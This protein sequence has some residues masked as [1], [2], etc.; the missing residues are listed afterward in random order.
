VVF[1]GGGTGG[2]V[3]PGLAL[4]EALRQLKPTIQ[5]RWI[6][7]RGRIE[8]RAVPRAGVEITYLEVSFLK[9]R[10]GAALFKAGATIPR[11]VLEAMAL[12]RSWRAGAVVGLGGFV[13]GPVC[14]AASI[15]RIPVFLLEQNAVPGLTNRWAARLARTVYVSF[16]ESQNYFPLQRTVVAGNPVRSE[17]VHLRRRHRPDGAPLNLLVFGG[18]QG[19]RVL[20]SAAPSVIAA[21]SRNVAAGVSVWHIAGEAARD[22]VDTAYQQAGVHAR[23]DSYVDDMARAYEWADLVVCRAGATT[24]AELT[25][26]GLPALYVP[27]PHAADDHQTANARAL[28]EAGA[29]LMV[30]DAEFDADRGRRLLAGVLENPVVLDRMADNARRRGRGDAAT[31]IGNDILLKLAI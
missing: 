6:G 30:T 14:L 21:A 20:N 10:Q 28:V 11:A 27:F 31:I 4:V 22:A 9:G 7:T 15:L 16:E 13:S 17:L 19:A 25:A 23:V 1:A 12:L 29:G 5:L 2:H 8:E 18:S 26:I 3:Y 24:I